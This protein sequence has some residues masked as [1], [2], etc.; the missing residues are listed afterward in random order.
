MIQN[1]KNFGISFLIMVSSCNNGGKNDNKLP[2]VNIEANMK[3]MEVINEK[4]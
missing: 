3:K 1:L 4:E 2:I